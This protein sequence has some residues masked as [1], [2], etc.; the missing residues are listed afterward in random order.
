[1]VFFGFRVHKNALTWF[2]CHFLLIL[3]RRN[4]R[5]RDMHLKRYIT[6][7]FIL[8]V[9]FLT[10]A[11]QRDSTYQVFSPNAAELGK[12]GKIPVSYFTGIPNISVPLT[13][14]KG[15]NLT[16]PVHLTYHADGNKPEQH[17]GW[18]GQGW[19][20]HAG[21]C[22][23]RIINGWKDFYVFKVCFFSPQL[24]ISFSNGLR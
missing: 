9:S 6:A 8:L 16:L 5:V 24:G 22:I 20:L 19:T 14:V 7:V 11:A 23:N 3:E 1:M 13:E 15:K 12:Y 4:K 2:L 10:V 21:G 17:P 18:V